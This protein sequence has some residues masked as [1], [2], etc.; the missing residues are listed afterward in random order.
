MPTR[1]PASTAMPSACRRLS[2]EGGT[3]RLGLGDTV[4][5]VLRY[6]PAAP[7]WARTEA[8]LFHTAFLL[9]ARGDLGAWL[10]H[11]A[12][13]G[14]PLTGGADHLVSEAVY[15]DD[16]EGNG[17]EIYVDRLASAWH[18]ASD[19]TVVMRNERLDHAGLVRA[20]E[21]PWSG[22][23]PGS[24]V[25]H[26]HLQVG[27]ARRGGALLCG[28]PRLRRHVSLLGR[29]VPRLRRL[30]PPTGRQ[31][32]EQPW[33]RRTVWWDDGS[34][35]DRVARRRGNLRCRARTLPECWTAYRRGWRRTRR[36]RPLGDTP[37]PDAG[38]VAFRAQRRRRMRNAA[39]R[40]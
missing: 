25:G 4:L 33:R 14:I 40:S 5:L 20:T 24:C 6:D 11:A 35:G 32:L 34:R 7:R 29:S 9:P 3:V 26:V 12:R 30:P 23:P 28:A 15:L 1:S 39:S 31:R 17:I 21:R 13:S 18:W 2:R 22:M 36:S 38:A 8:G 16:P 19:D 37:T 27:E 10:A